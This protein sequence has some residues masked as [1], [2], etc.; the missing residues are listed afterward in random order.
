MDA[1]DA[2]TEAYGGALDADE[3]EA[4][5]AEAYAAA[6][7][8]FAYRLEELGLQGSTLG[9]EEALASAPGRALAAVEGL[10][11]SSRNR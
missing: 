3:A 6:E 11:L 2:A 7:S 9:R 1:Y 10:S 5:E 8:D 4:R